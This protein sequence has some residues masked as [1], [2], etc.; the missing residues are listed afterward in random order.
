[1]AYPSFSCRVGDEARLGAPPPGVKSAE[2]VGDVAHQII[3]LRFGGADARHEA[4]TQYSRRDGDADH[5]AIGPLQIK[6]RSQA[7]KGASAGGMG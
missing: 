1:M 2:E 4:N 7:T 5:R 6:S 3:D